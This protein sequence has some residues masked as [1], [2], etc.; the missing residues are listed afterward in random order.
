MRNGTSKVAATQTPAIDYAALGAAMVAALQTAAAQQAAATAPVAVTPAPTVVVDAKGRLMGV[1]V[2]ALREAKA[3]ARA[4]RKAEKAAHLAGVASQP[5]RAAFLG[6]AQPIA[7][8]VPG[9]GPC[10]LEPGPFSTGSV[11]WRLNGKAVVQGCPVTVSF[12]LIVDG[13]KRW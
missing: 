1:P 11:G 13:S 3:Q 7:F 4:E 2:Q 6:S 10:T 12:Q 5:S 8:N 9:L